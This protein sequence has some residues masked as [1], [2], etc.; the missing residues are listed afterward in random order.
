MELK[1]SQTEK[2]LLT[3][4]AGESMAR[5]K[6]S[7]YAGAARKEGLEKVA[8][9]FEATADNE[10][11]HAKEW[12]KLLEGIGASCENLKKAADG[13]HFEWNEMYKEYAETAKSEGFD[14][15]AKKFEMVAAVEKQHEYRFN[16]FREMLEKETMFQKEQPTVFKC[17]NCG[18]EMK[19]KNAPA[20]CPICG[21]KTGYFEQL[22]CF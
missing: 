22:N 5:N 18:Y 14:D 7:Y 9:I 17:M 4:F 8:Q 2:N 13:E 21:H 19:G 10:R 11:A 1:G 3:A 12:F 6:Y 20:I 15:I 16:V